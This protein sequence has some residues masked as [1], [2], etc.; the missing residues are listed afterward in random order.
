MALPVLVSSGIRSL[1]TR[2]GDLAGKVGLFEKVRKS[3]L[4][5]N[6]LNLT[7]PLAG[8]PLSSRISR[9]LRAKRYYLSGIQELG[10]MK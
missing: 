9:L 8:R 2:F 6:S 5:L 3:M 10:G 1:S 7:E 4:L